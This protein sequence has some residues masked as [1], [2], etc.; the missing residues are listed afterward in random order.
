MVDLENYDS[1][2]GS[3]FKFRELEDTYSDTIETMYI[4]GKY[5]NFIITQGGNRLICLEEPLYI[6]LNSDCYLY[7]EK[8]LKNGIK[9]ANVLIGHRRSRVVAKS[10]AMNLNETYIFKLTR[11]TRSRKF[12]VSEI[13]QGV[14]R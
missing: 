10:K 8:P 13:F 14:K 6:K 2:V 7:T 4:K 12:V 5:V 9:T 3:G 1:R 11:E